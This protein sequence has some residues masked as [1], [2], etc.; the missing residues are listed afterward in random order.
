MRKRTL[1]KSP[2]KQTKEEKPATLKKPSELKREAASKEPTKSKEEDAAGIV[3]KPSDLK[4]V[5]QY[6]FTQNIILNVLF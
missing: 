6:K 3:A 2:E 5:R 1:N 4:K